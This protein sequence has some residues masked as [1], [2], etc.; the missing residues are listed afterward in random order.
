MKLRTLSIIGLAIVNFTFLQSCGG[1]NSQPIDEAA[2]KNKEY[3][4]NK[5]EIAFEEKIAKIDANQTYQKGNSLFYSRGDGASVDVEL[6]IDSNNVVVKMIE[7]YTNSTSQS[8]CSNV[9]Y[10]ENSKK[11]ATRE[12]FEYSAKDSLSF[13]ERITF[14]NKNEKPIVSKM[15][16]AY[17]EEE[18]DYESFNIV[19][20]HDCNI[21]RALNVINQ[22]DEYATTFR[23]FVKED[24]YLYLIVGENDIKGYSSSLV[25]QMMTATIKKLQL[26]ELKMIGA[27]LTVEFQTLNDDQGFV[28]Q[29][30]MSAEMR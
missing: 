2:Q 18:L 13:S 20:K 29:I 7:H 21:Q 17:Y 23:G 30:L 22:V 1:D 10:L 27:P 9:F 6:F 5:E 11:I 19:E 3:V 4:P 28:Y 15:R 24:P 12:L 26:N 8:I 25:V 16:T 14:Y